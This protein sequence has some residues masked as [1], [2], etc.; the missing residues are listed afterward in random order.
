MKDDSKSKILLQ[1]S[2]FTAPPEPRKQ[3]NVIVFGD[4]G[5]GKSTFALKYAPAPVAFLSYDRRGD[6][7]AFQ[8][9]ESGRKIFFTRIEAPSNVYRMSDQEAKK[10][11]MACVDKTIRNLEIAAR[12]SER[13][14]VRTIVLDTGTEYGDLVTMAYRGRADKVKDYGESKFLI[15]RELWRIFEIA[16]KSEA[17]LIVLGRAKPVWEDNKPSGAFDL[18][19]PDV[20][21]DAADWVGH[22]RLKK[23]GSVKRQRTGEKKFEM[24]MVR[25]K[26][27]IT[28][29]GDVY[30]EDDWGEFGPFVWACTMNYPGT[31]PSD[32]E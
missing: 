16:R 4:A 20:F 15:N 2:D 28:V 6:H 3:A 23:A 9:H 26:I 29:Q 1:G 7:A 12:E 13:G 14:N 18:R 31:I 25:A 27:D 30:D 11:G 24:E 22:I 21:N 8:A 5:C 17:H 32:W 19:G 10:V